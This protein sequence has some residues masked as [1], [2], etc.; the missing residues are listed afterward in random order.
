MCIRVVSQHKLSLYANMRICYTYLFPKCDCVRINITARIRALSHVPC[1]HSLATGQF[2]CRSLFVFLILCVVV[3]LIRR[4][5][6]GMRGMIVVN[7]LTMKIFRLV[8]FL[9]WWCFVR[10]RSRGTVDSEERS[11][12]RAVVFFC[13]EVRGLILEV[14]CY[15]VPIN[16]TCHSKFIKAIIIEYDTLY[17]SAVVSL[18]QLTSYRKASQDT[19]ISEVPFSVL[20]SSAQQ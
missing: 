20:A 8:Q 5:Y 16:I 14:L 7:T 12:R 10:I 17:T 19:T 18:L 9:H 15:F 2:S 11:G 13:G 3:S 4:R 1:A 6:P